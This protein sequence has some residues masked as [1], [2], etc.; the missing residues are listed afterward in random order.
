[1]KIG[2]VGCGTIG[3]AVAKAMEKVDVV[4]TTYVHDRKS[5]ASS[6]VESLLS[7]TE[8]VASVDMLINASDLVV[9]TASQEA[10]REILPKSLGKGKPTVSMS[11]GALVDQEFLV[12]VLDLARKNNAKLYIPSGAVCG[13]DGLVAASEGGLKY[14]ELISVKHPRAL[15][16]VKF[17]EEKGIDLDVISQPMM[18]Y[19]GPAEDAVKHFPKN[20]NV[21]ATISMAGLGFARTTVT[22]I[23][24][25][26]ATENVH[27]IVAQGD[28]GKFVIEMDNYPSPK[29]PKTS[30]IA[31]L[32]AVS[33]V[34]RIIDNLWIG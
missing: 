19:K 3:T 16:G 4:T 18:I 5:E 13:I 10:A 25:P 9:E 27:K 24:D 31:V 29:N 12:E 22:I 11:V 21:A 14:V 32:S 6:R 15:K 33:T 8:A 30:Y 26:S 7:K 17:L 2:I 1:V 34:K 23:A 20:I 28:F